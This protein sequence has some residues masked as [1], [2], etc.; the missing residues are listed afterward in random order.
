MD[1]RFMSMFQGGVA[2]GGPGTIVAAGEGPA[3][4]GGS[5]GAGDTPRTALGESSAS[6]VTSSTGIA[7]LLGP[8]AA[9]AQDPEGKLS[10][11][12]RS[13]MSYMFDRDG[14]PR[15]TADRNDL[16]KRI[17]QIQHILRLLSRARLDDFVGG[18]AL[19]FEPLEIRRLLS[20]YRSDLDLRLAIPAEYNS[21]ARLHEVTEL[22]VYKSEAKFQQFMFFMF[23][24]FELQE[25]SLSD[26]LAHTTH[27]D[28]SSTESSPDARLAI[29]R[30]LGN[31]ALVM[32]VVFGIDCRDATEEARECLVQDHLLNGI[33][34]SYI[35]FVFN[36][37]IAVV[38][39]IFR[40]GNKEA[41]GELIGSAAFCRELK[42]AL[43]V[44][45]AKI[46]SP[47]ES[48]GIILIFLKTTYGSIKWPG[49]PRATPRTTE[50]IKDAPTA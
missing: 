16:Q 17:E 37:A 1:K 42:Q 26:F 25:G 28:F 6:G 5:G 30:A 8:A 43:R 32:L 38:M 18:T 23:D 33:E 47:Y 9:G 13:M 27:Y 31:F 35:F 34:D 48:A 4:S 12:A 36:T 22:A 20:R 7:S 19:R 10:I 11:D 50:A 21:V 2:G 29:K 49:K 15:V 41:H 44:A 39:R 24:R 3:A 14:V 45:V 46:P 40:K